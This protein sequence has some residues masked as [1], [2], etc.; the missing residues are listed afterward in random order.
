MREAPQILDIFAKKYIII[1]VDP[2]YIYSNKMPV[3]E[4]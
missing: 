3:K 4:F 1:Y 2:L